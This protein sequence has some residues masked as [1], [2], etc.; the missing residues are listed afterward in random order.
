MALELVP[1]KPEHIPELGR[2]CY[3][4]FKDLAESSRIPH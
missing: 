1:A 3:E 2:I 4:A